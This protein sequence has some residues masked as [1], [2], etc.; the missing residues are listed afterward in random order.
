V[1]GAR[2]AQNELL[3]KHPTTD[4]RVFVIW[5]R[6]YPGDAE[7]KWP[8]EAL[9]D[10]RAEHRWDEP[11][12]AGRW[13]FANLAALRP[14]RGGDGRFP[15]RV[16]ALWD[17]YLLFDRDGKWNDAPSGLLSWGYPVMRTR[18]Q[19]M[20]DFLYVTGARAGGSP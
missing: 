13:F 12:A 6:M 10:R 1:A 7:S 3:A 5:F 17:S 14:S 16:D 8:Q 20:N 11:K 18:S 9:T 4:V 19:L 2:W 15:Q